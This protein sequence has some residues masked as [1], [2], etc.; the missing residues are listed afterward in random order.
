MGKYRQDEDFG[1]LP[2]QLGHFPPH[3]ALLTPRQTANAL[4]VSERTL[5]Y[6]TSTRPPRLSFVKIGKTRRYVL[7]DVLAA[8]ENFKIAA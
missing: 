3:Q 5:R 8:I 4:K 7:G 2:D 1:L 6:W